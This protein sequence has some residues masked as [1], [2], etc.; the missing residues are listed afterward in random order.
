MAKQVKQVR[1]ADILKIENF[2]PMNVDVS[3]IEEVIN[4][5]PRDGC[6]DLSEAEKLAT[7]FLRCADYCG[8]LVA[9]S[10]RFLGYR[11]AEKK[12]QKGT[13][14]EKK[15][16]NKMPATTAREVYG[17]DEDYVK[18][19]DKHTEA[20]AWQIWI[21]QKY[22]NLIRAHVFCKDIMKSHVQNRDM[23]NWNGVEESFERKTENKVNDTSSR[24]SIKDDDEEEEVA[25]KKSSD[26]EF[27]FDS[28][29]FNTI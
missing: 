17:N 4:L 15:I 9:Q 3:Y 22:D 6:I 10:T 29:D 26:D 12:S 7:A 5:I 25:K 19:C 1:I 23:S 2:D 14:I 27:G 28:D 20:Q 16:Q 18:S 21:T 24:K 8:D 11:D 13:A